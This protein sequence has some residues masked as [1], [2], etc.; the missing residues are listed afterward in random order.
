MR[1][2]AALLLLAISLS[3]AVSKLYMKDGQYQ[4]VREY[5]V[6]G[7]RVKF[8]S[9]ER[10]E[11]EEVPE[12]LVDLRKTESEMVAEKAAIN[13]Q[14]KQ[15]S[16]EDAAVRAQQREIQKIPQD[17]GVYTV[18]PAKTVDVFL[19]ADIKVHTNKGRTLLT[20][21]TGLPF[22]PGKATVELDEEHAKRIVTDPRQEFY[23]QLNKEERFEIIR[24]AAHHDMRIAERVTIVPVSKEYV[25]EIDVVES[26]RRQLTDNGLF[27]IWPVKDLTPGEYAMIEFTPGKLE[28]QVWDFQF[29][30]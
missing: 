9:V 2:L 15:L 11:W 29:R 19:F 22:I 10:S 8:Y 23:I 28:P 26:F 16:E 1:I 4:R 20:K 12:A 18:S 25:E 3:A 21:A 14:S 17:P 30:K 27:K 7:D 5:K 13:E 24:L 6:E